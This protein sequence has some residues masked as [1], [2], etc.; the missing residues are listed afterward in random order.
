MTS[1][2]YLDIRIR[3]TKKENPFRVKQLKNLNK[4]MIKNIK[5]QKK[6]FWNIGMQPIPKRS[7]TAFEKRSENNPKRKTLH[8]AN[9]FDSDKYFQTVIKN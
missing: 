9:E 8:K 6:S 3:K 5:S 7:K 1:S 4:F 2:K